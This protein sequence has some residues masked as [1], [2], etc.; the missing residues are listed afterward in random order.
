MLGCSWATSCSSTCPGRR[1][2]RYQV[3]PSWP[4]CPSSSRSRSSTP[5][6]ARP[7]APGGGP[8]AMD[9][10]DRH[11]TRRRRRRRRSG[12]RAPRALARPRH[13]AGL[14]AA[15]D[16]GLAR[17]I[18]VVSVAYMVYQ[19]RRSPSSTTSAPGAWPSPP[20][21][22]SSSSLVPPGSTVRPGSPASRSQGSRLR[23]AHGGHGPC[24]TDLTP[25]RFGPGSGRRRR[26]RG[27]QRG[28]GLPAQ[29][30]DGRRGP[31]V[32][33]VALAGVALL[34]TPRVLRSLRG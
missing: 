31:L 34:L 7:V 32:L 9:R 1:R 16:V 27:A 17:A 19:A 6:A 18:T 25:L 13:G 3:A 21:S 33:V 10:P 15:L 23:R 8:L 20:R 11:V 29:H 14:P 28:R 2:R 22:R 30:R 26:R 5:G 12:R 24:R 4:T